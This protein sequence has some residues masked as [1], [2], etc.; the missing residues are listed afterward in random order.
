MKMKC[1]ICKSELVVGSPKKYVKQFE[2]LMIDQ[3]E[4]TVGDRIT[5]HCPNQHC[6]AHQNVYW[7]DDGSCYIKGKYI[8]DKNFIDNNCEAFGSVERQ[9]HTE[10]YKHDED[11]TFVTI[12]P[13][14]IKRV[15]SYKADRD[16]NV[17][18]RK[19]HFEWWWKHDDQSLTLHVGNIKMFFFCVKLYT[20]EI[21]NKE[22]TKQEV[23]DNIKYY[24]NLGKDDP[25]YKKDYYRKWTYLYIKLFA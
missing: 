15:F 2:D 8:S 1:S 4:Q 21:N 7:D 12:G 24:I 10:V 14:V 20:K 18:K 25:W 11:Y 22:K 17:L 9:I 16:G 19:G 6:E 3:V 13:L 5:F 23:L